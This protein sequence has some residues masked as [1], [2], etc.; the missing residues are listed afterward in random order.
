MPEQHT[1]LFA[2]GDRVGR[3]ERERRVAVADVPV[4]Q[5]VPGGDVVQRAGPA[6]AVAHRSHLLLLLGRLVLRPHEWRIAEDVAAPLGREHVVPVD[7]QSVAM[8]DVR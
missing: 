5:H 1:D 7:S 2:L 3:D 6:D 4:S 8:P